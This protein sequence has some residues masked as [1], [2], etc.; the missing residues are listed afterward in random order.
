MSLYAP[1]ERVWGKVEGYPWWPAKV[2]TADEAGG[3]ELPAG[4]D[5]FVQYYVTNELDTYQS[6]DTSKITPFEDSSE[7]AVTDD[8]ALNKAIEECNTDPTAL[9]LREITA[10]Q[11]SKPE[12]THTR[13]RARSPKG[14]AEPRRPRTKAPKDDD[15]DAAPSDEFRRATDGELLRLRKEIDE[16]TTEGNLGELRQKL[17]ECAG[18][19]VSHAQLKSTKIGVS[20]GKLYVAPEFR[21]LHALVHAIVCF[22]ATELPKETLSALEE[23]QSLH[24]MHAPGTTIIQRDTSKPPTPPPAATLAPLQQRTSTLI[25]AGGIKEKIAQAFLNRPQELEEVEAEL[26]RTLDVDAIASS[27][28]TELTSRET[29]TQATH[30]LRRDGHKELRR[31]LLIGELSPEAFAKLALTDLLTPEEQRLADKKAAEKA[32]QED[33]MSG[34]YSEMF[35]CPKCEKSRCTF[36]EK[37]IRSAD[38]PA[39]IFCKCLECANDW[40]LN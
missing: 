15:D 7:K 6:R 22:W 36:V 24:A 21:P 35:E 9:P 8:P 1:G 23:M 3:N 39:T 33:A 4:Y 27:I 18:I 31:K 25:G 13:K 20:V 28:A 37:Q 14:D 29:R 17:I 26:G 2:I 32:A 40:T 10:V 19:R 34:A 11:K 30:H 12:T 38:E 16:A 5:T